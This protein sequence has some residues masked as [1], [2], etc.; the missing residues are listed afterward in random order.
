MSLLKKKAWVA[1]WAFLPL[2]GLPSS[3]HANATMTRSPETQTLHFKFVERSEGLGFTQD[4]Y[5]RNG[6]SLSF[7][8]TNLIVKPET[9]EEVFEIDLQTIIQHLNLTQPPDIKV[10]RE[11]ELKALSSTFLR[12]G[13][14]TFG[15]PKGGGVR[16]EMSGLAAM[17]GRFVKLRYSDPST[18]DPRKSSADAM[19]FFR[20]LMSLAPKPN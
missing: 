20:H 2:L 18:D 8:R 10:A 3:G 12:M 17:E 16:L 4:V 13:F 9:I 19:L 5:S 15:D 14:L 6:A 7:I 11:P 1:L